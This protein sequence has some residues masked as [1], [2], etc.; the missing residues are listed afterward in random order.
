MS[1]TYTYNVTG[2]T[3]GSCVAYLESN[4][5]KLNDIDSVSVSLML[6]KAE[7]KTPKEGREDELLEAIKKCGFTPSYISTLKPGDGN[8][9]SQRKPLGLKKTTNPC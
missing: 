7:I 4:I 6:N 5:S 3:C 2:M 1:T 9:S 8:N